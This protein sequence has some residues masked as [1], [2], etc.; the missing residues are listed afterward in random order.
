MRADDSGV[1]LSVIVVT[2][3][4][5]RWLPALWASLQG[6]SRRGF[7]VVFFDNS[8]SDGT[9]DFT[10][11]CDDALTINSEQNIGFAAANNAAARHATGSHLL[12]LNPDTRLEPNTVAEIFSCVE[13]F[14]EAILAPLQKSY[15][16]EAVLT[17]GNGVDLLGYPTV[18]RDADRPFYADGAAMVCQARLFSRLGGFDEAL[19]MFHEDI[20]LCWRAQL[21]GHEVIRCGRAVVRH[22]SGASAPGGAHR[23][24]TRYRTTYFRRYNGEKNILRNLLK[25]YSALNC[26]WAIPL[27]LMQQVC[28]MVVMCISGR[29]DFARA[30]Y[31][32]I[33]WNIGNLRDTLETRSRVQQLRVIPDRKFFSRMTLRLSKVGL[34]RVLGLPSVHPESHAR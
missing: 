20:D 15:D 7:Q 32:A 28:E 16:G 31:N 27:Y 17:Q 33:A 9:R 6:Q 34:L 18:S 2:Y 10:E 1:S 21:F 24:G 4:S 23:P 19:F 11:Q 14:P 13:Q 26:V 3:N 25:N 8:S 29:Y 22:V 5:L 12:F 30:D